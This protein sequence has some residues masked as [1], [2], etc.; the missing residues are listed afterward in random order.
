M[1]AIYI[2]KEIRYDGTQ[3]TSHFAYRNFSISG[4]SIVAFEGPVDVRLTEMVDLEDVINQE[5]ISS[6]RM[7]SFM[8]EVFGMDL[9]GTIC[10]QRLLTAIACEEL[11]RMQ[12]VPV[13]R[14]GDDIYYDGRKLSVSIATA[15]PVSTMIHFAVNI[16]KTGAPVPVSCLKEMKIKPREF[17]EAV[18]NKFCEEYQEILFARVKVNWVK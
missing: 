5:P 16:E 14:K 17:A 18:L 2:E 4:D 7:L 6:D 3:L 9:T 15:S 10:L 1:T 12:G 11:N 8:I 13:E